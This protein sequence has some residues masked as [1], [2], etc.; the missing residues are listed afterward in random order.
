MPTAVNDG[1]KIVTD[2]GTLI[3]KALIHTSA[4]GMVRE[5]CK[6]NFFKQYCFIELVPDL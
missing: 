2:S 4:A 5:A 3:V 1:G 6:E